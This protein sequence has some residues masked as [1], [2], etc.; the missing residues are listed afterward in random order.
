MSEEREDKTIYKVS[1][2]TKRVFDCR[3][4]PS[5]KRTGWQDAWQFRTEEE[6]LLHQRS[7]LD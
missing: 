1:L 6:C 5:R 7:V 3:A 4:R 2:T